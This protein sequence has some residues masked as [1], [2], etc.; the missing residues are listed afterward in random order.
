MNTQLLIVNG[1]F[2]FLTTPLQIT[3]KDDPNVP[4]VSRCL[5]SEVNSNF[6]LVRQYVGGYVLTT[7]LRIH[8]SSD[9]SLAVG[10]SSC[11]NI[12]LKKKVIIV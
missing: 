5:C 4:S 6:F 11:S 12:T 7:E 3:A 1:F 9:Y 2:L 8:N 10:Q